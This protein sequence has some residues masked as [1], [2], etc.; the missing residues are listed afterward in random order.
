MLEVV[1]ATIVLGKELWSQA[2]DNCASAVA[3]IG[4]ASAATRKTASQNR[5]RDLIFSAVIVHLHSGKRKLGA[6][7]APTARPETVIETAKYQ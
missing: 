7:A 1:L 4:P 2:S 3:A 5:C 6:M